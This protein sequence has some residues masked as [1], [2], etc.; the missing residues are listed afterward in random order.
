MPAGHVRRPY[1]NNEHWGTVHPMNYGEP[2]IPS[3][4]LAWSRAS[5][6]DKLLQEST[7][8]VTVFKVRHNNGVWPIVVSEDYQKSVLGI[9]LSSGRYLNRRQMQRRVRDA[10][11]EVRRVRLVPEVA[12]REH[13]EAK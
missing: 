3:D 11:Y 13:K 12:L 9:Y 5:A 8:L 7:V 1:S 10:G 6:W 2:Y 4:G